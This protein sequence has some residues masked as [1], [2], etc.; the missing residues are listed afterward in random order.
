M[1]QKNILDSRDRLAQ[2]LPDPT[3]ISRGT[4]LRRTIR[5]ARGCSK[6]R[7]GGGHPVWVLTVTYPG[8]RTRQ[9]SIR[10]EQRAQVQ[11]W[12]RNYQRLKKGL[13][14]TSLDD[15]ML[16]VILGQKPGSWGIV[17]V[18]QTTVKGDEVVNAAIPFQERAVPVA[19][20]HFEYPWKTVDPASQNTT[21]RYLLTWLGLAVP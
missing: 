6:C 2:R 10:P 5:P 15:C 1:K 12:V 8:G 20:V 17:L 11:Q 19:W 3:Q 13:D 7:A 21:E 4:L 18:D 9:F 14:A 16:A